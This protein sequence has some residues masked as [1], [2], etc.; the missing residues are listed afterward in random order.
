MKPVFNIFI[1]CIF[2]AAMGCSPVYYQPNLMNTPNFREKG[3]VHLA[4]SVASNGGDV[5]AAYAF[6]NHFAAQINFTKASKTVNGSNNVAIKGQLGEV[7]IGYFG[8]LSDQLTFGV[9][10][11]YGS[12]KVRNDWGTRG[13]S[14]ASFNKLF[15]QPTIG[16]R[17]KQ[18]EFI[19]AIKLANLSYHNQAQNFKEQSFIDDFDALKKPIPVLES[20]LTFRVGGEHLK[21]LLQASSMRLINKSNTAFRFEPSSLGFGICLQ[22][23][24]GTN[25]MYDKRGKDKN[26]CYKVF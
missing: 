12:G 5:Q 21:F 14:L 3:E 13:V 26:I 18:L 15:V 25:A 2:F 8:L 17:I 16:I 6:T 22:F 23:G 10:G 4:A 19:Y 11:G 1:C 9:F 24:G 20:G 7:A